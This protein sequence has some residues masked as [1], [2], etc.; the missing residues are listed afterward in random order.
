MQ[1][2]DNQIEF[3]EQPL[4]AKL[5]ARLLVLAV[6]SSVTLVLAVTLVMV[7]ALESF[8]GITTA[9]PLRLNTCSINYFN[10]KYSTAN[11]SILAVCITAFLS[12]AF[13][14]AIC[15]LVFPP[16]IMRTQPK[17]RRLTLMYVLVSLQALSSILAF[18]KYLAFQ[19]EL[20]SMDSSCTVDYS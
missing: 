5:R 16:L 7:L 14:I 3:H 20:H 6:V 4:T 10:T 13:Q 15:V 17:E 11:T 12:I 9:A 2:N 19:V 18:G 8:T 1:E